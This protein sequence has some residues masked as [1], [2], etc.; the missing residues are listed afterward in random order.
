M[1]RRWK[2]TDLRVCKH[3]LRPSPEEHHQELPQLLNLTL[4]FAWI[5]IWVLGCLKGGQC[6]SYYMQ[7]EKGLKCLLGRKLWS[8]SYQDDCMFSVLL[9][10]VGCKLEIKGTFM[11]LALNILKL[12]ICNCLKKT[13]G[14]WNSKWSIL[15]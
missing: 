10:R 2:K 7:V 15:D 3:E 6:R 14:S 1:W 5:F 4:K 12:E 11:R 8:F 9:R 13:L